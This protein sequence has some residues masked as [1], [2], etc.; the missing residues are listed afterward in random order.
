MYSE[1]FGRNV[2]NI[3]VRNTGAVAGSWT[4]FG[5]NAGTTSPEGGAVITVNSSPNSMGF[6]SRESQQNPYVTKKIRVKVTGTDQFNNDVTITGQVMSEV[7][8]VTISPIDF[9]SPTRGLSDIIDLALPP[10]VINGG[11]SIGGTIDA[12][13]TMNIVIEYEYLIKKKSNF[14]EESLPYQIQ[15]LIASVQPADVPASRKALSNMRPNNR[16]LST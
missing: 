15:S 2:I 11:L 14:V 5:Y 3:T 9:E 1:F 4:A 12:G 10:F 7:K 16:I 8:T 6:A 13:T